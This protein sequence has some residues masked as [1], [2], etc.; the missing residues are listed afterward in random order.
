MA[1]TSD[2]NIKDIHEFVKWVDRDEMVKVFG[3]KDGNHLWTKLQVNFKG[4]FLAFYAYLDSNNA[5]KIVTM[6]N[7]Q[8]NRT[9]PERKELA[10]KMT[11][12]HRGEFVK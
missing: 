3:T 2:Q 7:E 11:L 8:A 5:D 6:I 10:R 1:M 12:P 4:D 9:S